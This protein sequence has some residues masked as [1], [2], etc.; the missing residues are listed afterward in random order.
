M[1]CSKALLTILTKDFEEEIDYKEYVQYDE[2][3]EEYAN[4]LC[5]LQ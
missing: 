4:T 1:L 2:Y 5:E 3:A